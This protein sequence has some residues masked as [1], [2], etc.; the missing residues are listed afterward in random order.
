MD[1]KGKLKSLTIRDQIN[2][3]AQVYAYVGTHVEQAS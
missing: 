1:N 3:L 2:I